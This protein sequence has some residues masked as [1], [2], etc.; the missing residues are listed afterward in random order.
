VA[1]NVEMSIDPKTKILTIKIDLKKKQGKSK[2]GNSE[3]YGTTS[4]NVDVPDSP[5]E[6]LKIGVNCYKP[7]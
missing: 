3:I 7:V 5:I 4:G 2:S 6:D 1:K